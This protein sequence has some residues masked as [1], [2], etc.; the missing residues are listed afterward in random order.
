MPAH[1]PIP[2]VG[3]AHR[4]REKIWTKQWTP[5]TAAVDLSPP[6]GAIK[7]YGYLRALILWVTTTAAGSGGNLAA[8]APWN[9]FSQIAVTQPNGEEMFGG[10]T[11]TGYH[12]FQ[13]AK[14][15]SW[16]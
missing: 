11:F 10:P 7:S 3:A 16:K 4:Y 13:A 1:A 6:G 15:S 9:L 5:G 8:D 2:F 12:A 14:H